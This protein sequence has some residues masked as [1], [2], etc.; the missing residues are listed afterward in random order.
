MA[1]T[2]EGGSPPSAYA[3]APMLQEIDD[4]W[5]LTNVV[6]HSKASYW[7]VAREPVVC[8]D[9]DPYARLYANDEL[10][11]IVPEVQNG[12]HDSIYNSSQ[13]SSMHKRTPE[14]ISSGYA[15]NQRGTAG[16]PRIRPQSA[17]HGGRQAFKPHKKGAKGQ[18]GAPGSI[19][20]KNENPGPGAYLPMPVLGKDAPS[21]RIPDSATTSRVPMRPAHQFDISRDRQYQPGPQDFD[22]Q[23]DS[24]TGMRRAPNVAFDTARCRVPAAERGTNSVPFQ[25]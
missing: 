18:K 24:V 16:Q 12:V 1:T 5:S 2:I 3:A 11:S 20:D 7:S 17:P 23:V 14:R 22:V 19:Y 9:K 21:C 13:P 4:L 10:G 25:S 8:D 6:R 15:Q